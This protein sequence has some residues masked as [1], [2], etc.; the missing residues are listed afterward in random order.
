MVWIHYTI[1]TYDG[2]KNKDNNFNVVEMKWYQDVRY[3]RGL[4]WV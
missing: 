1:K 2:A 3:N 4:F